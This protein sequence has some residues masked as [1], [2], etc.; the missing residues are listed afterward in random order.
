MSINTITVFEKTISKTNDW[1]NAIMDELDWADQAKAYKALRNVLHALRD[2]LTVEEATDLAAQLPM[3]IRGFYFEGWN[4]TG[5]PVRHQTHDGFIDQ[6]NSSFSEDDFIE[7]EDITR[8][9]F[10]VLRNK[11]S[12]GEI[13]DVIGCMP[14]QLREL[15]E[16]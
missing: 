8:A 12:D 9:V 4:P 16:G 3:L 2:C 14:K 11:I 6:V 10:E 1:L 15:W 7:A 5:K 13:K